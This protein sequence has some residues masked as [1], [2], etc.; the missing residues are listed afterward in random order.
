[1]SYVLLLEPNHILGDQYSKY[2]KKHGYQIK[3]CQTGQQAIFKTDFS[4]PNLIITELLLAAHNGIEFLYEL[5]SYPEWQD[6]PVIILSRL[7]R[8]QLAVSD[9]MLDELGV[10]HFL[11]KP[12]TSLKRLKSHVAALQMPVTTPSQL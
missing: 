6:I 1:M 11:Y 3:W 8:S 12:E 4:K 7:Q 5:R 9:K 10:Q 2:L